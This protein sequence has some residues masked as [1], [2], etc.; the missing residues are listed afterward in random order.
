MVHPAKHL[1]TRQWV[2]PVCGMALEPTGKPATATY[3]EYTCPMHPE[4]VQDHPGTCSKCGMV[5]EPRSVEVEERNEE[6]TS[7]GRSLGRHG[8]G[9]H[10]RCSGPGPGARRDRHGQRC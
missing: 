6:L 7:S 3:S 10:Q 9:W 4:I 5:L 1:E 8:G 2:D